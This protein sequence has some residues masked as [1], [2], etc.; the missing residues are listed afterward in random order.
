MEE[1]IFVTIKDSN[2]N[3]FIKEWKITA[4]KIDAVRWTLENSDLPHY[5]DINEIAEITIE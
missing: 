1:L 2:G 5:I 3:R 4:N